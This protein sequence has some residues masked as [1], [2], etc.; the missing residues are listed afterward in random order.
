[1]ILLMIRSYPA[2]NDNASV[3]S[4]DELLDERRVPKSY[5]QRISNLIWR[6]RNDPD[7]DRYRTGDE[8]RR[9]LCG[10]LAGKSGAFRRHVRNYLEVLGLPED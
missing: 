8:F 4:V 1:V 3:N 10:E 5:R 7:S 2:V 6:C 9:A